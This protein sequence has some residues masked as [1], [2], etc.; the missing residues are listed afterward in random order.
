[1]A[2][3]SS[4]RGLR[5]DAGT[6]D[7]LPG[8]DSPSAGASA[9][10]GRGFDRGRLGSP[11]CG[12]SPGGCWPDDDG[13]MPLPTGTLACASR[14]DADAGAA[15]SKGCRVTTQAGRVATA[16]GAAKP[17]GVDGIACSS[18][19]DCAPGFDCVKDTAGSMCRRTCCSGSCESG[20]GGGTTGDG[21]SD[22][23]FCDLRTL[24]SEQRAPVCMPIKTCALLTEG[25]CPSGETCAVVTEKGQTGCVTIGRAKVDEPCDEDT[26][27]AGLACLGLVGDRRCYR[28]CRVDGSECGAN[29]MCV[30]SALFQESTFGVCRPD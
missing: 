13:M 18:G 24:T 28:L 9:D 7:S 17:S 11:L 8:T 3:T 12:G 30:T 6:E 20:A 21:G 23:S 16:C 4:M 10:A 19:E 27:G 22:S 1:M 5:G 14:R 15:P 29:E 25:A 26:C 2:S